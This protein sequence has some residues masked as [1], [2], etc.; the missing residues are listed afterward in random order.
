MKSIKSNKIFKISVTFFVVALVFVLGANFVSAGKVKDIKKRVRG[1]VF[2]PQ[3]NQ[4]GVQAVK[5][6][7]FFSPMETAIT[8][9]PAQNSLIQDTHV[10][11]T[12]DGWQVLPFEKTNR[13]DVWLI[14]FDGGWKDSSNKIAYNLPAGK[15]TYTL[16]VRAKNSKGE[17]DSTAAARSFT[18][19]VSP[20]FAKVK[21][22]SVSWLGTSQKP[23]YESLSVSN[24]SFEPL[25]NITGWKVK[26][27]RSSFSF[28]IPKADSS[29]NYRDLLGNDP[30]VLKRGDRVN[31]YVG[32]RSPIGVDF[33]ENACIGFFRDSFEGYDSLSGY[34]SCPVPDPSSYSDFSV[35]CRNYLRGLSGCNIPK[36]TYNQFAGDTSCRDFIIKNYNY[37]ACTERAK[38]RADFYSGRWKVYL[39]HSNE[40]M[41]D[42]NDTL[43]LYDGTGLLVDTYKY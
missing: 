20:Y 7:I 17:F 9:G 37:Q 4:Q 6:S 32:K 42:L 29:L 30:I 13:F 34:G 33:Q 21:I 43:Y 16:L 26:I 15:K 10:E 40:V 8:D 27:K 18:I 39:N 36:L 12:F 3:N 25:V 23:Q 31:I 5:G 35:S 22:S 11:F 41:D 38:G 19:N 1:S 2:L 28:Y 14:G 24:Q